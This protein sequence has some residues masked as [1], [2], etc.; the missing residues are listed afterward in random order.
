LALIG[1]RGPE[2]VALPRGSDVY[3]ARESRDMQAGGQTTIIH[4]H[5]YGRVYLNIANTDELRKAL[6][7]QA[8]LLRGV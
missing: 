6:R 1:E 3:S 2:L 5:N 7:E 8:R 4:S